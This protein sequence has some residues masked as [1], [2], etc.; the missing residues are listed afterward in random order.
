MRRGGAWTIMSAECFCQFLAGDQLHLQARKWLFHGQ[1]HINT[2]H[3]DLYWPCNSMA[4]KDS[5]QRRTR[6][7]RCSTRRVESALNGYYVVEA[8]GFIVYYS[9]SHIESHGLLPARGLTRPSIAHTA[10][11]T[12]MTGIRAKS[13]IGN[14]VEHP[15]QALHI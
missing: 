1:I 2:I 12:L 6:T 14:H 4:I 13:W 8:G 11:S 3:G 9:T 15:S 10:C 7:P 5:L